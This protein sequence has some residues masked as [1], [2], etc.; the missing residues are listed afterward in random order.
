MNRKL[1]TGLFI[2]FSVAVCY[3]A[4]KA[5]PAMRNTSNVTFDGF[6]EEIT[7]GGTVKWPLKIVCALPNNREFEFQAVD[8]AERLKSER[9]LSL[10]SES[11]AFPDS[12]KK[13]I[14]CSIESTN[15]RWTFQYGTKSL[16][17][18]H[19]LSLLLRLMVEFQQRH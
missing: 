13:D 16:R 10:L 6:V 7:K 5:I 4:L 14:S 3:A 2:L 11:N 19:S 9:L 8:D 12:T 17:E 1:V 18:N 15:K